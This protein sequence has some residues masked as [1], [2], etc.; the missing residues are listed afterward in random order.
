MIEWM[1]LIQIILYCLILGLFFW[2]S[3]GGDK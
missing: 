2:D 1:V 3:Q